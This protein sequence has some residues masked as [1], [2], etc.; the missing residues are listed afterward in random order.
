MKVKIIWIIYL[1]FF[2]TNAQDK[3]YS[4]ITVDDIP[5]ASYNLSNCY[6]KIDN[7]TINIE[8]EM[9]RFSIESKDFERFKKI[10]DKTEILLSFKYF[11]NCPEQRK[12]L[13]SIPLKRELLSQ[14]FLLLKVYN[15]E[16]YPNVFVTNH[17]YG[18]EYI[19]PL[20]SLGLPKRKK[21]KR[22]PCIN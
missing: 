3:I 1:L 14:R 6:L 13:Y 17:G 9:G 12:Y 16:S 15:Y 5:T 4:M 2:H 8:Y 18:Y 20:G 19:S 22:N 11:T 7:D 21:M 10:D